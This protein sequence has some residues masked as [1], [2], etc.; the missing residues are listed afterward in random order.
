MAIALGSAAIRRLESRQGGRNMRQSRNVKRPHDFD[1]DQ[2]ALVERTPFSK[3]SVD[4][5]AEAA[6]RILTV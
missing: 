6:T 2:M 4:K 3:D 1:K 5:G